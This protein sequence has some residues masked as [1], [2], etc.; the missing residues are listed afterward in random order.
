[1]ALAMGRGDVMGMRSVGAP[2]GAPPL[3]GGNQG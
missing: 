3:Q 2:Y 1:M